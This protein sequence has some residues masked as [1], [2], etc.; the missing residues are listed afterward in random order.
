MLFREEKLRVFG[1]D[2]PQD[3]V[4]FNDVDYLGNDEFFKANYENK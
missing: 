1:E 3:S 4:N 2:T